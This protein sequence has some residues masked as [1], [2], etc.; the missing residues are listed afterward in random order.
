MLAKILTKYRR[1]S[2]KLGFLS[3][4]SAFLISI[5]TILSLY[6]LTRFLYSEPQ[7]LDSFRE[8]SNFFFFVGFQITIFLVFISRFSLLFFKSSKAFGFNQLLWAFGVILL[9]SYWYS[10]RPLTQHFDLYATYTMIFAHASRSFDFFGI[11]YLLLSPF[12][13]FFILITALIK[14]R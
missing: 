14:P 10:S 3:Q 9:F 11:C 8:D 7:Y 13:R 1:L 5:F 12:C 2:E 6:D 4:L